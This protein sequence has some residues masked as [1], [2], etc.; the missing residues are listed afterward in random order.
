MQVELIARELKA[1]IEREITVTYKGTLVG[2]Y[3]ADLFVVETVV[4]E[5]KTA[6][7]YQTADEA[8]LLNQLKATGI[9]VGLLINFGRNKV[10]FKRFFF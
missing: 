6:R 1:E 4:V 7:E 5:L 10:E 3:E 9:R 8:Q 2:N